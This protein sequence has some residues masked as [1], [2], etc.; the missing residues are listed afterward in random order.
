LRKLNHPYFI[1]DLA[2]KFE[3]WYA[4]HFLH[5]QFDTI[6]QGCRFYGYRHYDIVGSSIHIGS[7]NRFM[8]LKDAPIRFSI[9]PD[10]A[11]NGHISIGDYCVINPGVRLTSASG[12]SI[13][14]NCMLAMHVYIMDL[15][16]HDL[17][18]RAFAPGETAPVVL[19]D[20][21]W[22]CDGAIIGK[23]VTIGENSIVA[24]RAVVT[25]DVPAN[26]VVGG[27]PAKVIKKLD[28]SIE[29]V[30]RQMMYES[31]M[32]PVDNEQLTMRQS[33][34][35]NRLLSWLKSVFSPDNSH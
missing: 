30:T 3:F 20:N 34:S 1:F 9:W 26:T 12:I 13:G 2:L 29:P 15:D 32:I 11:F 8:A 28:P 31:E 35:N 17:Y 18:H 10:K 24:A 4:K 6:G 7:Y 33:L 22:V 27:N 23:G 25:K 5:P 16:G 19:K 14:N 21:V